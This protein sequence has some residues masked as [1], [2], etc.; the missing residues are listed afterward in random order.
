MSDLLVISPGGRRKRPDLGPLPA[1]ERYDGP[2]HRLVM[3]GV[4]RLRAA[5]VGVELQFLSPKWGLV[6][7]GEPLLDYDLSLD[8]MGR[9]AAAA[10]LAALRLPERLSAAIAGAPISLLMLPGKYLRPLGALGAQLQPPP[11]GR[12]LAFVAPSERL[13][14]I[15]VTPIYC[16]PALTKTFHAP[17]TALKG[18]LFQA[19]AGGIAHDPASALAA[20]RSDPTPE[21]TWRLIELGR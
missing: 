19:L 6:T 17:N 21:T 14:G 2:H 15:G 16:D 20:L 3:S 9:A 11:G 12:L 1:E 5:G 18:R 8:E 13:T 4:A 10:H 7:E